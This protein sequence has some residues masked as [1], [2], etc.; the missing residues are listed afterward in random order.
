MRR[1]MQQKPGVFVCMEYVDHA[2]SIRPTLRDRH[3]AAAW[4]LGDPWLPADQFEY[5]ILADGSGPRVD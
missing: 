4:W 1:V 2:W 5:G 3:D